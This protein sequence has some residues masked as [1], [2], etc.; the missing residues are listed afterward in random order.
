MLGLAQLQVKRKML[1]LTNGRTGCASARTHT[2]ILDRTHT[3]ARTHT[4]THTFIHSTDPFLVDPDP[5]E[6]QGIQTDPIANV[7]SVAAS[8]K[9]TQHKSTIYLQNPQHFVK[10]ST[11]R[12]LPSRSRDFV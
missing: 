7:F 10:K 3:H 9:I 5:N 2:H 8:A 11:R 12:S 4:H 1:Q 6:R